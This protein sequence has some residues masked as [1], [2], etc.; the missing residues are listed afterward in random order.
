MLND[1]FN[2]G[3]ELVMNE[4]LGNANEW[5]FSDFELGLAAVFYCD[6]L[7]SWFIFKKRDMKSE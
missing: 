5:S 2:A 6:T 3:P 7:M 4:T 1:T